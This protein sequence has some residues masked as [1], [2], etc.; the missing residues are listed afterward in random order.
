MI[1]DFNIDTI[2]NKNETCNNYISYQDMSEMI[3][4]IEQYEDAESQFIRYYAGDANWEYDQLII[5]SGVRQDFLSTFIELKQLGMNSDKAYHESISELFYGLEI[6][7]KKDGDYFKSDLNKLYNVITEENP[8]DETIFLGTCHIPYSVNGAQDDSNNL[9][10][11]GEEIYNTNV[12]I[13][14][15]NNYD[16]IYKEINNDL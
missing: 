11:D 8:L 7:K 6:E 1:Y 3:E 2:V 10:F 12:L 5:S 14:N 15:Y 16:K 9:Y 13:E 4:K